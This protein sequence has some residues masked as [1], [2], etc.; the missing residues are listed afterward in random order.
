[1]C[2]HCIE[3]GTAHFGSV[4]AQYQHIVFYILPYFQ[5]SFFF[6]SQPEL[7]GMSFS[8]AE[9]QAFYV[10]V[11]ADRAEAQK[12]VNEFCGDGIGSCCF[13]V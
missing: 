8:Y 7:V 3:Q 9:N 13:C 10:P 11:P 4:V 1:M 12:I 5:Y 6:E 2:H